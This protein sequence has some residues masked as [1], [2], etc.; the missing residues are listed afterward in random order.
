MNG[1]D[2]EIFEFFAWGVV[3]VL[4]QNLLSVVDVGGEEG[5]PQAFLGENV[6]QD[7]RITVCHII[8]IVELGGAEVAYFFRE[9]CVAE[10]LLSVEASEGEPFSVLVRDVVMTVGVC[11]SAYFFED[12]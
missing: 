7:R 5:G 10:F 6:E 4:I 11:V 2:E 12:S 9:T 3:G 1:E 8:F